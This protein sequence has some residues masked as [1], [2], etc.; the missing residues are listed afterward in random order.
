MGN[1]VRDNLKTIKK[2]L[3][4]RVNSFL[5]KNKIPTKSGVYCI[6]NIFS[7]KCYVG[8][9]KNLRDRL[10]KRHIKQLKNKTHQNEYL[11]KSWDKYG[12]K[13][14]IFII[15]EY[16]EKLELLTHREQYYLNQILKAN[17]YVE[18]NNQFFKEN[19]YNLTPISDFSESVKFINSKKVIQYDRL[20]NFIKIWDSINQAEISMNLNGITQCI[21]GR[22]KT[23]GNF[24]WRV[25]NGEPISLKIDTSNIK[26]SYKNKKILQYSLYGEF[27]KEWKNRSEIKKEFGIEVDNETCLSFEKRHSGFL[28]KFKDGDV[29]NYKIDVPSTYRGLPTKKIL[30]YDLEGK[31]IREWEN[32]SEIKKVLG[33]IG[34]D[35]TCKGKTKTLYGYIWK[36][37]DDVDKSN[38]NKINPPKFFENSKNILQYDMYGSFVKEWEKISDIEKTLGFKKVSIHRVCSGDRKTYMDY[39]WKYKENEKYPLQLDMEINGR[40]DI[41]KKVEQYD[42]DGNLIKTWDSINIAQKTLNCKGIFSALR[43]GKNFSCGFNWKVI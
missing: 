31:L 23:C 6:F 3:I 24:V 38:I 40:K 42:L 10:Y 11:Q 33:Y 20:G 25:Y 39:I 16:V 43:K 36:F 14:F 18:N 17:L 13:N 5:D 28:W 1:S 32:S 34:I 15:L 29:I 9:S 19:G 8:V 22:S 30:Q 27:I 4:F 2:Q 26:K 12:E 37:Y 7:N 35:A 41:I 21:L